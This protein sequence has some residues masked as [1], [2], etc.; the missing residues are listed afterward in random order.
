MLLSKKPDEKLNFFNFYGYKIKIM[1]HSISYL[2]IFSAILAALFEV[3][4]GVLKYYFDI[5]F[6]ITFAIYIPKFLLVFFILLFIFS[7]KKSAIFWI[8]SIYILI[9]CFF[10]YFNGATLSGIFFSF[11]IIAPFIFSYFHGDKL[12][13][14]E[15][16]FVDIVKLFFWITLIGVTFDYLMV[17]P[18]EGYILYI[19]DIELVASKQWTQF[20]VDRLAGFSRG[21]AAVGSILGITSI[22]IL[23]PDRKV[24]STLIIILT[25]FAISVTTFKSALPAYFISAFMLVFLSKPRFHLV[26]IFIFS[27]AIILVFLSLVFGINYISDEWYSSFYD[28]IANTWPEFIS[29]IKSFSEWVFGYGF[30]FVGTG[31]RLF[32]SGGSVTAVADNTLLYLFG[33]FGLIGLFLYA[34]V[35]IVLYKLSKIDT[36]FF[37]QMSA[38]VLYAYIISLTTDVIESFFIMAIMGIA[39][40]L[41]SE[42][43]VKKCAYL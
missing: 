22:F 39:F 3:L 40:Y 23:R 4:N 37:K 43:S 11:S 18:W 24:R 36:R 25:M 5:F 35:I 29:G 26:S 1:N 27:V 15:K 28:R 38:V 21:S 13:I 12:L 8:L 20:G 41:A 17:L 33:S 14:N 10:A 42:E 32:N 16:F 9:S 34:Y 2:I 7:I 30:G 6:N 19:N 31:A